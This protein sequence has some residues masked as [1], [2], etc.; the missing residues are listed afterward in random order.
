[1]SRRP[2]LP[3]GHLPLSA[4]PLER[5]WQERLDTIAAQR[6]LVGHAKLSV[7][8]PA[9]R[10]VSDAYNAAKFDL[11]WTPARL[12]ARLHFFLPRDQAKV[13]GALRDVAPPAAWR[14][15]GPPLVIGD[16]GAGIG[17]S[18]VGVVRAL[19]AHGVTRALHVVLVDRD[20]AALTLAQ[21]VLAALPG[22]TVHVAGELPPRCDVVVLAQVLVE[23]AG[24]RDDAGGDN[25]AF[26]VLEGARQR[27]AAGGLFV[28]VEPAL[29]PTTRRLQRL[30]DR[31]V[32]EGA[33]VSAP[34]PHG[35]RCAMLD[36]PGDWCHDDLG[37][38]LPGWVHPL[39]RAAGLRW[40]GL[41]FSRLVLGGESPRPAFRVVAPPRDTRGRNERLL[42]GEHPDGS[43]LRWVDRLERHAS[44]DNAAFA[45]LARGQ[46]LDLLPAGA[47]VGP[48]TRVVRR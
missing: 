6:G 4:L 7:L 31:L 32:A 8:G 27:L 15:E 12:A 44:D 13:V 29:L 17:A 11:A 34:C 26:G 28:I 42:C 45:D 1:M 14:A 24:G 46:G 23:V 35:G 36:R 16:L 22:V 47:R 41:T 9:L 18:A 40:Q 2:T 3:P 10:E 48:D 21:A 19:R 37:V 25:A 38:D 43:T 39:A 30:R 33:V 5:D 20:A